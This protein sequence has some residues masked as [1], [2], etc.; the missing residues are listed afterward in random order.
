MTGQGNLRSGVQI[1]AEFGGDHELDLRGLSVKTLAEVEEA[2]QAGK[3]QRDTEK[4]NA[5]AQVTDWLIAN[6]PTVTKAEAGRLIAAKF[7]NISP[8][9]KNRASAIGNSLSTGRR[10]LGGFLELVDG[11]WQRK[12]D[13]K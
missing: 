5:Y 2:K 10:G 12:G 1:Q 3:R 9:A 8:K 4:G 11:H 13:P 6:H 7:R